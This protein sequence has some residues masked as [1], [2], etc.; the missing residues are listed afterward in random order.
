MK[1]IDIVSRISDGEG[2]AILQIVSCAGKC[3]KIISKLSLIEEPGPKWRG[4]F[5][6]DGIDNYNSPA[7]PAPSCGIAQAVA[8]NS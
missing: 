1:G 7:N 4:F 8:F 6:A 2:T 3:L 5:L